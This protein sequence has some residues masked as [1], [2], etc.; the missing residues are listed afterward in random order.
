MSTFFVFIFSLVLLSSSARSEIGKLQNKVEEETARREQLLQ[1]L[2][3]A[4]DKSREIAKNGQTRQACDGLE[5]AYQNIPES[6][7]ATPLARK[8]QKTLSNLVL[9][10]GLR[11]TI[12]KAVSLNRNYRDYLLARANTLLV[13]SLAGRLDHIDT[14]RLNYIEP[15]AC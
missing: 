3:V 15:D 4:F 9:L 14:S 10:L 12:S 1:P 7:T 5:S 2:I 8:V 11:R 13:E 6:L